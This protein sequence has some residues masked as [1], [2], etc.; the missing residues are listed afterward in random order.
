[1]DILLT[2]LDLFGN[3]SRIDSLIIGEYSY[4]ILICRLFDS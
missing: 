2:D 1:M 4:G 3:L